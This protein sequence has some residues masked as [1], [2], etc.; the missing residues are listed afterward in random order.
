MTDAAAQ[1]DDPQ[2]AQAL[3][4]GIVAS[5]VGFLGAF[6]VVLTGLRGVGASPAE[7]ASG[8]LAV[9]VAMGVCSIG[10]SLRFRM[11]ISVAWST[12]GA[13]LLATAGVPDGGYP[14]ALGAFL[15]CGVL[16]ALAGAWPLLGALIGR[17]PPTLASAMLAG[18]LLPVC[19]QPVRAVAELP[20]QALPIVLT[21]AVMTR[22][23]RR[24]ATPAALVVAAVVIVVS[25]SPDLGPASG[26]LPALELTAPTFAP[27]A[28]IGIAL[29]L[30]VVTMAGQ[31]IPGMGVLASFGYRPSLRPI[32]VATGLASVAAAP[33]GGHSVNLAAI[34]AALV[35]GP[36]GGPDP[37]RRWPGGISNGV[38]AIVLGLTASFVTVL[39]GAAPPLLI[40][41]AA[42][43]AL[44]GALSGALAAALADEARR[45]A[46][47]ITFVVSAS[48]ITVIGVGGA[49]WGLV[50]GLAFSALH[51]RRPCG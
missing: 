32:L 29:P 35:S 5:L 36:E 15:V 6:A 2:R 46:A 37:A 31:N 17:I 12:P 24:W 51:R 38:T 13:A 10:L 18:I 8:L 47:L 41:A 14:A 34:S 33:V 50:A 30:F 22:L 11:P 39:V 43:L 21:W 9:S 19:L 45:E 7:A 48:G 44:L 42:G 25:E 4:A 20:G 40:E 26:L 28:L 27:G 3:G 16:L 23:A 1:P 49:F